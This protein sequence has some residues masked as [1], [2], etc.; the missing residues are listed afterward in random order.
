MRTLLRFLSLLHPMTLSSLRLSD[1]ATSE[2]WVAA[3][4]GRRK[5]RELTDPLLRGW[6]FFFLLRAQYSEVF[7]GVDLANSDRLIVIKVLK[8]I[9]KK[10]VKRELKV[11][12][13]LRGGTNII[14]LLDV[15][16]DPQVRAVHLVALSP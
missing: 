4:N 12:S 6:P 9:K 1:G 16:R 11:L 13:N 15:V 2:V 5:A 10:K 14:E 7:E 8:P 3:A